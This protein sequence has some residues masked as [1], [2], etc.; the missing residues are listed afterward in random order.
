MNGTNISGATNVVLFLLAAQ[1][2]DY[3]VIVKLG[4]TWQT[5]PLAEP[6]QARL[7]AA[8]KGGDA[9]FSLQFNWMRGA[10][11][12]PSKDIFQTDGFEKIS[13]DAVEL[14]I[15]RRAELNAPQTHQPATPAAAPTP[16]KP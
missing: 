7:L 1:S 8:S 14:L 2:G 9:P 4:G 13:F 12:Q 3:S 6:E 5:R 10:P 15:D 16:Q 11:I